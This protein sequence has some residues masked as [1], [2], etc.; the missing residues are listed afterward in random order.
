[1]INTY[2]KRWIFSGESLKSNTHFFLIGLCFWF[3]SY[4]NNRIWKL[5]SFENN[6]IV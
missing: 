5:H 2:F 3:Y 1:M 6:S 4:F